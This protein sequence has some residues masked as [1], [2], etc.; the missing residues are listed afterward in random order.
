MFWT[1]LIS[2]VV[3]VALAL[4]LIIPGGP[5]LLVSTCVISLIGLFEYYRALGLHK[6]PAAWV[7]YIFTV[8]YYISFLLLIFTIFGFIFE[9]PLVSVILSRLGILTPKIMRKIRGG[10]IVAIFVIAAIITPP[11]IFS[12]V[13]VAVPMVLLYELSIG[14][15]IL[16]QKRR[17]AAQ[18]AEEAEDD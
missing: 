10:A 11:D 5:V 6:K 1:R 8:L 18:E 12:Q 2:G 4:L 17:K 16:F 3:L 9:M 14:L 13:M 7:G 15:C